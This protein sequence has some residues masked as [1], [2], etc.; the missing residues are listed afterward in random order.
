MQTPLDKSMPKMKPVEHVCARNNLKNA[1]PTTV[2]P[3]LQVGKSIKD[4]P[5]VINVRRRKWGIT[6]A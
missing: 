5:A 2:I 4:M 1:P 6:V 3:K